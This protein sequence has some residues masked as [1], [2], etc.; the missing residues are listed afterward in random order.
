[1]TPPTSGNQIRFYAADRPY[2]FSAVEGRCVAHT[3]PWHVHSSYLIGIVRKGS[4]QIDMKSGTW[5]AE[6][7]D[8]YAIGPDQVH[9][10][11]STAENP[12]DYWVMSISKDFLRK[13]YSSWAGTARVE[14]VFRKPVFRDPQLFTLLETAARRTVNHMEILQ[15]VLQRLF[16]YHVGKR[17]LEPHGR[18]HPSVNHARKFIHDHPDKTIALEQLAKA[19]HISPFH[20]NR[21][22]RSATGITPH[23]YQ[24]HTR[25]KKAAQLL[26]TGWTISQAAFETGFADQSH[27]TRIFKQIMGVTPGSFVKTSR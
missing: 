15:K 11:R 24:L 21:L 20:L 1:M 3:F 12:L 22:F 23:N 4:R 8:C 2:P 16:R 19:S 25:I 27:L 17:P 14:A 10:C 6:A 18:V 13:Q 7:G 9:A 26:A 5:A